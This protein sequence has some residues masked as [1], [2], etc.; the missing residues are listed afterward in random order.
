MEATAGIDS[1]RALGSFAPGETRVLSG[2]EGVSFVLRCSGNKHVEGDQRLTMQLSAAH[3]TVPAGGS[4]SA[5]DSTLA[6]L[7]EGWPADNNPCPA[8]SSSVGDTGN[9]AVTI[10]APRA[11]GSY[12]YTAK[13][14]ATFDP[15][16]TDDGQ[17]LQ[18]NAPAVS[19]TLTVPNLAPVLWSAAADAS[20]VKGSALG[21]GGSF[22]DANGDRTLRVS[23]TAGAGTV[24]DN[25]DGTWSWSHTPSAAG[26]G[27]VTV[28]ATDGS[29]SVSD[30]FDWTATAVNRAPAV[31]TPA[32]DAAGVE[33]ALLRSGDAFTDP[34]GNATLTVSKTAGAGTVTD[35]GDG[36]WSWSHTPSAAGSGSVTVTA[37]DGKASVSDTFD[38]TATAADR[39][40]PAVTIAVDPASP[41]GA[42]GWH[43]SAVRVS[44]QASDA[45][46][47]ANVEYSLDGSTWRGCTD[48]FTVADGAYTIQARATDT[49]GN[50][51]S[52]ADKAVKQD[53][54]DPT[55]ELEGGP[56]GTVDLGAAPAAP[57]C[58]AS[59]ATSGVRSCEVTGYSTAA[60]THT[61][62]ARATDNAGRTGTATRTY[63]VADRTPPAV[64][65]SVDPAAA[66]GANGW[67]TTVVKASVAAT[68][69]DRVTGV[70]YSLDGGTTWQAYTGA[71][72]LRDGAASTIKARASDPSGN[73]G[74][75]AE[76]VKQDTVDP[77]VALRGGPE[78]TVELGAV[79]PSPTCEA[80]DATSGVDSCV[81]SGYATTVGTHTL[82]ATATDEAGR[83][84]TAS[85][86]YTVA[87]RTAPE[88]SIAVDPAAA[89]GA[90][91]WHTS[92]VRVSVQ[93]SD[94]GGVASV[95]YSVDGSA[96]QAYR[97]PFGVPD[98]THTIRARATDASGNIG[99]AADR[100]VRQ[101]TVD[102]TVTLADGPTGTVYFGAIPGA[103]SCS[104]AGATSGVRSC[105]VTGYSTAVG[106]HTLT[107]TATDNAGRTA[108]A[109]RSYTVAPYTIK[110]FYQ[111][112]D[113]S[114]V[115]NTARPAAPVPLKFEV[116]RN[117]TEL[118]DPA[119][120]KSVTYSKVVVAS[121]AGQDEIETFSSGATS[122]R[123]D[124]TAGQFV[125]NWKTPAAGSYKLTLITQ[126]GSMIS[127]VFKLR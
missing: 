11:A 105:E 66:D 25:G 100:A 101:D 44:V 28:T 107:A 7:P 96:W 74:E 99:S 122:L 81:V 52:A 121:T 89:D 32:E 36:T 108:S 53:T 86:D 67:Y 77:T 125:Y 127:A 29:G 123:Y 58:A 103:P 16:K 15:A 115:V 119:T 70:E 97:D 64:T 78:G 1:S 54:V 126:D 75:A 40:A 60:G 8:G 93:A 6:S 49:S 92:A 45:G 61:L 38:W 21:T 35:N 72:E 62:T 39:T 68:D 46:G 73:V 10:T 17:D 71:V 84:A 13:Y 79:P 3:S 109:T 113:M 30:T 37:T 55:V 116:F 18:S 95:E 48:S 2:S 19:Y 50:T 34:D 43:T 23:K 26:S 22:T 114:G 9:S 118:T 4:L 41:D 98:G 110:G 51:G 5:T 31:G 90:D 33:G 87:D 59:D 106:T 56:E 88:V 20:G 63:T 12:S 120:V 83:T 104:A 42:D 24:T 80:S 91:G 57:T 27:S 112:V 111:P 82:M 65:I 94:L 69:N 117:A 14:Q 85:R 102:P 76:T 47:V 124:T